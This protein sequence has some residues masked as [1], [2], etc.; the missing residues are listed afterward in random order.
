MESTEACTYISLL[1]F[2]YPYT[3]NSETNFCRTSR[4]DSS[5]YCARMYHTRESTVLRSGPE[6]G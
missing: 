6:S 5:V 4:L 3:I 1:T 2:P